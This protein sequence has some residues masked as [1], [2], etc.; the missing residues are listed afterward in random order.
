MY[1][2]LNLEQRYQIAAFRKAGFGVNKIA[3]QLGVSPAT[4]SRELRRHALWD[5][6]E[7]H[8]AQRLA[9]KKK[10]AKS[11]K[12]KFTASMQQ[13]VEQKLR[14]KW[15]PEQ[16]VGRCE[17]ENKPIVSVERIYQHVWADK[18][19]GGDLYKCLRHGHKKYRKRYGSK[20]SDHCIPNRVSIDLR[21]GIVA[22][23]S[24]EGDWE[25][26][27]IIGRNQ[28]G[29]ILTSVERKTQ[30]TLI[31]KLNSKS[32]KQVQKTLINMFAPYKDQVLTITSDNGFE[33]RGHEY[34]A[35]KLQADYYFAHP[36]SSWERGLNE[37]QNKLIRQYIPK[38][39][40]FDDYDHL[41]ILNIQQQLN[42]RPRKK[43]NYRTP[44]EVF[45]KYTV[46]LTG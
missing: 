28:K 24:R 46:A 35:K 30:F 13:F 40:N 11:G 7:A 22:E 15:S 31:T 2:H 10:K 33:F 27:T 14:L 23:K 38:K 5:R 26:D 6:Y 8:F 4:I 9:V 25:I 29:A 42:Q 3:Q 20:H 18:E 1:K 12:R 16:I 32:Y 36:Y 19:Q 34:I 17:L 21:P 44:N 39:S 43:L 37:Y 41:Q 45:L